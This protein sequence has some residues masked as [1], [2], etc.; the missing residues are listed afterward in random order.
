MGPTHFSSLGKGEI[1]HLAARI[2]GLVRVV[3]DN[4]GPRLV[5]I[6][7]KELEMFAG[8]LSGNW[9]IDELVEHGFL[10]EKRVKGE[11]VIFP[12]EKLLENQ[13]ISKRKKF[14]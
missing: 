14:V 13:R 9:F 11:L 5:G 4:Y 2:L 8:R 6:K 7:K 3:S 12:T 1:E 10:A